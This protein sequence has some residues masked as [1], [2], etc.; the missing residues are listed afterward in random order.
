[1]IQGL[2]IG[3]TG[4]AAGA[5][6][7]INVGHNDAMPGDAAASTNREASPID[8]PLHRDDMQPRWPS[9]LACAMSLAAVG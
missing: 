6:A 1:L 2:L 5:R 4:L 9:H 3:T 7:A 8:A